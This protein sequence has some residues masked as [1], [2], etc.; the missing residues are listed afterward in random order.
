MLKNYYLPGTHIKEDRVMKSKRWLM[1]IVVSL[2][3]VLVAGLV[4]AAHTDRSV[5]G[6]L[7]ELQQF[8]SRYGTGSPPS[9]PP[10]PGMTLNPQSDLPQFA[11]KYGIDDPPR[12]GAPA[13]PGVGM[14]KLPDLPQFAS[15]Y[16]TGGPPS[17]PPR[18]GIS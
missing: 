13:N 5:T 9:E 18:P 1:L 6:L 2:A 4:F 15:K 14:N 17:E 8:V 16:G 7:S 12:N 10:R 3:M 11:S